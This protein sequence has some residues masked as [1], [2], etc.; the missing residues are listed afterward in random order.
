VKD[1]RS[2]SRRILI[3]SDIGSARFG[4]LFEA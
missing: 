2:S 1:V 4:C 3:I